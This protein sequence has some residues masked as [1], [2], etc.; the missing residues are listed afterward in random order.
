MIIHILVA[1]DTICALHSCTATVSVQED[2]MIILCLCY[3]GMKA[4]F[5]VMEDARAPLVAELS[6]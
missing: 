2:Y 5:I 3:T 6:H 4:L 1:C